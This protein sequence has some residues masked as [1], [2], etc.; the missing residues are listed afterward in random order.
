MTKHRQYK[1][2]GPLGALLIH[3]C[4]PND[5][6]V[7]SIPILARHLK[8]APWSLYKWISNVKIPPDRVVEIVKI[9][10]G[11]VSIEDFHPYVYR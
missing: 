4:P 2:L 11:R 3:A 7:Q 10:D 5:K 6:G 1:D 8:L 9:S